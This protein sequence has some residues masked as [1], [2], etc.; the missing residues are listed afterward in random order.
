[1]YFLVIVLVDGIA[2][3]VIPIKT[4]IFNRQSSMW[5]VSTFVL[6]MAAAAVLSY[7]GF[8]PTDPISAATDGF[9]VAIVYVGFRVLN[10][11]RVLRLRAKMNSE[12]DN[13]M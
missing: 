4:Q 11:Y 10:A 13:S 8:L 6:T 7:T 3:E 2:S 12:I 5:I 9:L 1:M